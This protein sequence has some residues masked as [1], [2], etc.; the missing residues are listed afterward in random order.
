MGSDHAQARGRRTGLSSSSH[1]T[2]LHLTLMDTLSFHSVYYDLS[3]V[4]HL[5]NSPLNP[6][7]LVFGDREEL[8]AGAAEEC[9]EGRRLVTESVLRSE[10]HNTREMRALPES[11]GNEL[12]S[13]G[14][15]H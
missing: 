3:S 11:S 8:L 4:T 5:C 13:R 1:S 2:P 10:A 9:E 14:R 6:D 15:E 7:Q 12:E